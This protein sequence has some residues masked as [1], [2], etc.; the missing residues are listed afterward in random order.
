MESSDLPPPQRAPAGWYPDPLGGDGLQYWDGRSWTNFRAPG[1]R[2]PPGSPYVGPPVTPKALGPVTWIPYLVLSITIVVNLI[3]LIIALSYADTIDAVLSGERVTRQEAFDAEDAFA[4]S[5]LLYFAATVAAA[6]GFLVWFSRGYNNIP[7]VVRQPLRYSTG[8][9]IGAW[10]IPIFNLFRPKQ[11]AND[12]WRSG[13]PAAKDNPDWTRL[14]VAPLVHWWW[15]GWILASI[16]AGVASMLI[17]IDP[18]LSDSVTAYPSGDFG[19]SIRDDLELEHAGAIVN[20]I[21]SVVLFVAAVLAIAFV[22][23][24]SERQDRELGRLQ[25][26]A[27]T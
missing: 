3:S 19:Q 6:I 12:L 13:D 14:T 24:A 1:D 8:W 16:V 22:N 27:S 18:V 21:S 2:P 25:Q 5:G 26:A 10:F 20:G 9:A 15:A 4:V 17:S 23:R 7:A 11:I